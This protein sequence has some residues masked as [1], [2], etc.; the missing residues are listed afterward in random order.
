MT[1]ASSFALVVAMFVLALTPG[2]GVFISISAGLQETPKRITAMIS[3]IITG[4]IIFL[5][6]S[7]YGLSWVALHLQGAFLFL[8]YAGAAYL[9]YLGVVML[10]NR[11]ETGIDLE[12]SNQPT[13]ASKKGKLG[14]M[15]GLIVTLANPKVIF[16]YVS[17]LPN[18]M[19]LQSLALLDIFIVIFIIATV[20]AISMGF[21]AWLAYNARHTVVSESAQKKLNTISGALILVT[22]VIFALKTG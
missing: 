9:C 5:M 17:F 11:S 18:F 19:D 3:G 22:G 14:Y 16:F 1:L 4:D 10:K 20:L 8:Q 7:I 2:P 21:Y 15:V 13:R 12:Q 6:L